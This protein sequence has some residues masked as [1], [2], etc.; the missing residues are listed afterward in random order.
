MVYQLA[1][2][3]VLALHFAFALF[4]VF[5]GL[6]VAWRPRLVCLHLPAVV[7][8]S[9]VNLLQQVCPL[10]PLENHFRR[11]AGQAGYAGTFIEQYIAPVLY[12]AGMT[13]EVALAAGIAL[14]LWTLGVYAWILWRRRRA[15]RAAGGPQD[16]GMSRSSTVLRPSR[17]ALSMARSQTSR[18]M[19]E[20]GSSTPSDVL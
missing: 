15:A 11:L 20:R 6:L 7:W 12:P 8:S 2:E 10:T 3:T 16:E 19:S 14:P 17:R 18:T 13:R 5:G 1:A 4:A 9:L